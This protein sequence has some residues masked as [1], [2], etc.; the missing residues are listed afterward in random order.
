[1]DSSNVVTNASNWEVL[2]GTLNGER[3]NLTALPGGTRERSGSPHLIEAPLGIFWQAVSVRC[4]RAD[5]RTPYCVDG[6][7]LGRRPGH[8]PAGVQYHMYYMAQYPL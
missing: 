2:A 1:M 4:W 3:E 8:Q 6:W 7:N 5:P